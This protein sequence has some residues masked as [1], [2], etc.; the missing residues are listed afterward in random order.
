MSTSEH[1]ISGTMVSTSGT[2][3]GGSVTDADI[4]ALVDELFAETD[5]AKGMPGVSPAEITPTSKRGRK[6]RQEREVHGEEFPV[7]GER[8]SPEASAAPMPEP[9]KAPER[10]AEAITGMS[11]DALIELLRQS[12]A[13]Y[14]GCLVVV[15]DGAGNAVRGISGARSEIAWSADGRITE[16]V[17]TL[18]QEG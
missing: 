13:C 9:S 11:I 16:M 12:K 4:D 5:F 2:K 17:L 15:K 1:E 6:N 8:E 3:K 10:S 14:K 7:R 18:E